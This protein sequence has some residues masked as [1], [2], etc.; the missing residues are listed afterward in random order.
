VIAI[1]G[2]SDGPTDHPEV[3]ERS[4]WYA[5][6]YNRVLI[7][8]WDRAA[9]GRQPPD[10]IDA[11]RRAIAA[12][13]LRLLESKPGNMIPDDSYSSPELYDRLGLRP[14]AEV[15]G[16]APES[17]DR[18]WNCAAIYNMIVLETQPYASRY[19]Y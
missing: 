3:Q 15:F 4:I 6:L 8:R 19:R 10:P 17:R 9:G 2:S 18:I 12:R 1:E 16:R 7:D 14:A 13:D 5:A 11:A